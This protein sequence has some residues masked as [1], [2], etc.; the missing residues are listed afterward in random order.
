[1]KLVKQWVDWLIIDTETFCSD[2]ICPIYIK[3]YNPVFSEWEVIHPEVKFVPNEFIPAS[4]N[5]FL[6]WCT[7]ITEGIYPIDI[8]YAIRWLHHPD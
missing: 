6:N 4:Y 7:C 3:Y 8:E 1:M 5:K 2:W